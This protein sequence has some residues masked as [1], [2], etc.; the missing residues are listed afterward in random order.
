MDRDV[1]AKDSAGFI[2]AAIGTAIGATFGI[3]LAFDQHADRVEQF[4]EKLQHK[5][6]VQE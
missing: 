1:T 2:G 4:H 5:I 6:E 3:W